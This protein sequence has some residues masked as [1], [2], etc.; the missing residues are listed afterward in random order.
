MKEFQRLVGWINWALNVH[1]L[2][3][4]GLATL[5]EKM[6]GKTE[7]HALC[8]INN[9]IIADLAWLSGHLRRSSGIFLFKAIAWTS[10]EADMTIYTDASLHGIGFWCS[11]TSQAFYAPLPSL[12]PTNTIFYFEAFVIACAVHWACKANEPPRRLAIHSDN[13][14][15]VDMFN[16]MRA[17][18]AYNTLL[19]FAV[20]CLIAHTVDLRVYHIAGVENGIADKLSR[21]QIIQ[22][23]REHPQLL[24]SQYAPPTM[25]RTALR[26]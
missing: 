17:Q 5:Y 14:N 12:P 15:S 20:D 18:P 19:L 9:A 21:F 4:P 2:L 1:P 22:L 6:A 25:D 23:I 24:I 13:K 7:P 10:D 8:Y 26:G 16:S 11:N 3:R